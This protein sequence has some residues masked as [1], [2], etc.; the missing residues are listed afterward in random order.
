LSGCGVAIPLELIAF[1]PIVVAGGLFLRLYAARFGDESADELGYTRDRPDS[2]INRSQY[3]GSLSEVSVKSLPDGTPQDSDRTRIVLK[4]RAADGKER[5]FGSGFSGNNL[6]AFSIFGLIDI[7]F[8]CSRIRAFAAGKQ[9]IYFCIVLCS[10]LPSA[11]T[12]N[13]KST[14]QIADADAAPRTQT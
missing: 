6:K 8:V 12:A 3:S 9:L 1:L 13:S 2:S 11:V 14:I 5:S 4:S 7:C 10:R